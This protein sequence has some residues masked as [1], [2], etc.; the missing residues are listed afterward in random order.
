[1]TIDVS[2]NKSVRVMYSLHVKCSIPN[3]LLCALMFLSQHPFNISNGIDGSANSYTIT[4]SEATSG[5]V[6]GSAIIPTSSCDDREC[7]YLLKI[8]LSSSCL[9]ST[10]SVCMTAFATNVIGNGPNTVPVTFVVPQCDHS[11]S[12][13]I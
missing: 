13:Y 3:F 6:C 12:A 8:D 1:M 10:G 2:F 5:N 9:S 7:R 4:Y 11:K